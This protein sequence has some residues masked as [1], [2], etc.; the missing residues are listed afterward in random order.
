MSKVTQERVRELFE[1]LP[2]TGELKRK[3]TVGGRWKVGTIAG[4]ARKDGYKLISID[5]ITNNY[6]H[7]IVWLYHFG[8]FPEKDIDHIN[9]DPLD[10]RIENLRAVDH[11]DNIRNAK[12][13]KHNTSGVNGVSWNSLL[14]KWEAHITVKQKKLHLGVYEDIIDASNARKNANKH[15]GYHETHGAMA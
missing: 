8:A 12:M 4:C 14:N 15:Y 5:G 11:I 10:N 3:I 13:H 1:Y 2:E 7:R 9:H 6:I